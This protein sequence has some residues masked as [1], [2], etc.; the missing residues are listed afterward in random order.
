M[1]GRVIRRG[2]A[3]VVA[4]VIFFMTFLPYLPFTGKVYGAVSFGG[5][6]LSYSEE[7]V[8]LWDQLAAEAG[9]G[10]GADRFYR[11]YDTHLPTAGNCDLQAADQCQPQREMEGL[12][13]PKYVLYFPQPGAGP[14]NPN[15]T[16]DDHGD[17]T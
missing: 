2:Y 11:A 16:M 12:S 7:L 3:G 14:E 17:G 1:K 8:A 13:V 10:L 4:F 9:S 15:T 6:E 5:G